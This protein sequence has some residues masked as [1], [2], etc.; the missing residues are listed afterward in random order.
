MK[1]EVKNEWRAPKSGV[2]DRRSHS[3]E[4]PQ[5][6]FVT[7]HEKGLSPSDKTQSPMCAAR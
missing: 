6:I 4:G 2:E 7:H 5:I 3:Q 1:I